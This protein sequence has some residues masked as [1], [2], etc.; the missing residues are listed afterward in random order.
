MELESHAVAGV[1][2]TFLTADN[3]SRVSEFA[4][5]CHATYCKSPALLHIPSFRDKKSFVR[6]L[7][8]L[9]IN[10]HSY[11]QKFI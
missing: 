10:K 8:M 7:R 4:K 3:T 2:F 6:Y 11:K 1:N 9:N 5:E